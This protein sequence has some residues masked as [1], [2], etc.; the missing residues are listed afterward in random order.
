MDDL[1]H[2]G[3]SIQL[4]SG[5]RMDGAW[6]CDYFIMPIGPI[7]P[8]KNNNGN[9]SSRAEAEVAALEAAQAEIDSRKPIS[10]SID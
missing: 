4:R 9:F 2:N 5:Q 10:V 6:E 3:W 1:N 7:R 8:S